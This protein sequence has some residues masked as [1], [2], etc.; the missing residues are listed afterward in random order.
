MIIPIKF[1]RAEALKLHY[2][3]NFK[4]SILHHIIFNDPGARTLIRSRHDVLKTLLWFFE[5][6]KKRLIRFQFLRPAHEDR[7]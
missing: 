3:S 4:I 2:Q 5:S 6:L 7:L 1:P